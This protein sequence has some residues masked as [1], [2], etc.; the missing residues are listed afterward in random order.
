MYWYCCGKLREGDCRG[1]AYGSVGVECCGDYGEIEFGV[2]G[3]VGI[4]V[5]GED[6]GIGGYW[7]IRGIGSVENTFTEITRFSKFNLPK[8]WQINPWTA[9]K[10][11]IIHK[12]L[13]KCPYILII[14]K[15]PKNN[16]INNLKLAH[17]HIILKIITPI[18][19]KESIKTKIEAIETKFII[20]T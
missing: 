1:V 14:P 8:I 19:H 4:G 3:V 17:N 5:I 11:K 18:T 7:G 9:L 20:F 15:L 16:Q 12:Q 10:I 6:R 2:Y 13:P